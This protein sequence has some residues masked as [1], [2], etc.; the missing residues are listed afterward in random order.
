MSAQ[1]ISGLSQNDRLGVS[2]FGS[3]LVHMVV[4]LGVTFSLPKLRDL[5]G[6]PTLEI[7]LVQT[8]SDKR[9]L[10]PEFLAQANQEGGGDSDAPE[11]A[12][13][14]LPVREI[15]PVN[16][17]FPTFQSFPQKRVQS[18][19]EMTAMLSQE[20]ARK[21]KAREAKPDKKELQLQPPNL[22][23][24]APAELLQERARLN[25]EISRT[26]QEYQKRPRHKFLNAR[27]QEY[28]YDAYMDAWRAKVERIGNLNYPDDAKRRGLT[29]NLLLDVALN[30][31]GSIN[32]VSVRRSSGQKILDD[33]AVRIVELAAPFAPFPSEIRADLDVLHITRTWKF[34]ESGLSSEN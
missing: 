4:I 6:L 30:A 12:K 26:W 19:R 31:D 25:A 3:F 27:T 13:N 20:A 14:P 2:V 33:A 10:D 28:K 7:T 29:G 5:P 24:M 32:Q 15:S 22:G 18:E 16:R 9:T 23:F 11:I 34:N 17:D 21:I 8:A 1:I